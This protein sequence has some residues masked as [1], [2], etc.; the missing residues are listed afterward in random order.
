MSQNAKNQH[1]PHM[2]VVV[3]TVILFS[4]IGFFAGVV[5][6]KDKYGDFMRSFRNIR[7]NSN[8]YTFI[9]PLVG[10]V[11]APATDVGIFSDIK[12]DI[13][14][15]LSKEEKRGQLYSYSFYFRDMG[16]GLWF[17]SNESEDF[18]PASLFKLPIAMAVYKQGEDNPSFLKRRV[19]YTKEVSDINSSVKTN[20]ESLL[21]IGGE[22]SVE[23][24]VSIMIT[25]SDNGA[26]NLLLTVLDK[27]YINGLF[28]IVSLVDPDIVRTYTVSSRKY[29]LFLRVLYGS[30]Y[31]NEDHS[32]LLLKLLS[33]STFK[34]GMVAGVPGSIP[35]AH[36]FGTYEFEEVVNG[37]TVTTHQLHDCGVVYHAERPYIFCLMTKG[38]EEEHLFKI[39]A[40]VSRM[41]FEYQEK[42]EFEDK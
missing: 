24:L 39:I 1:V 37:A 27:Q 4:F 14:A 13:M 34:D 32:E 23:D 18:F 40:N 20:S 25:E 29:A 5:F 19:V 41:V 3:A 12:K 15:Y 8:K 10:N 9:N 31:L 21:V 30:S 16:S 17:G 26:K 33:K 36:K 2:V 42:N 6:E 38:K 35:V 28:T 22:Y 7:E 11:S